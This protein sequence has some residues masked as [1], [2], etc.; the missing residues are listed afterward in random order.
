MVRTNVIHGIDMSLCVLQMFWWDNR[1]LWCVQSGE[2]VRWW[3]ACASSRWHQLLITH[4]LFHTKTGFNWL[5][6]RWWHVS[7][8][9][10]NYWRR[11]CGN[12]TSS[13]HG[14]FF[15]PHVI[16]IL[17]WSSSRYISK[18]SVVNSLLFYLCFDLSVFPSENPKNKTDLIFQIFYC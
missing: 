13:A 14:S 9:A 1:G 4:P 8:L 5:L 3:R 12:Y 2:W 16:F 10:G 7:F 18:N 17:A 11:I 6:S 15:F